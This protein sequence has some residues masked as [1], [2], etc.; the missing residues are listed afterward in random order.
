[1]RYSFALRAARFVKLPSN[2]FGVNIPRHEKFKYIQ[3]MFVQVSLI[4]HSI[5]WYLFLLT[6]HLYCQIKSKILVNNKLFDAGRPLL[7]K[8]IKDLE[9]VES[10]GAPPASIA[11]PPRL[12]ARVSQR[13]MKS[14]LERV[15]E[16][17]TKARED[18]APA[19]RAQ[20]KRSCTTTDKSKRQKK[21]KN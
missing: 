10:D 4:A 13:R 18:S 12:D 9:V 5:N 19:A 14:S 3:D 21:A 1:M 20:P 2:P 15:K 16:R 8:V 6:F 7:E 17:A 11:N